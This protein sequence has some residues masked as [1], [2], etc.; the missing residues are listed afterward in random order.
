M[1]AQDIK[2][3]K[4]NCLS[5]SSVRSKKVCLQ[6]SVSKSSKTIARNLQRCLQF[7]KLMFIIVRE[8]GSIGIYLGIQGG[9]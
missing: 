4:M 9:F 5:L 2:G 8:T 6:F 7:R 1:V 3:K